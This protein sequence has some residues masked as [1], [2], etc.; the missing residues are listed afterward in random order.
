M[1]DD[2]LP[3]GALAAALAG[4]DVAA[5]ILAGGGSA[6][7]DE[8]R[9]IDARLVEARS[10]ET[11]LTEAQ[12]IEARLAALVALVRGFG[13]AAMVAGDP[14]LAERV[15]ADGVHAT[16]GAAPLRRR[17]DLALGVGAR[18]RDAAMEAGEV[19]A[20]YVFFGRL[21][22]D[23]HP[24]P[25]PGSLDLARWWANVATVPCIAPG[26]TDPASAVAVAETGADFVAL[27]SAIFEADNPGEMVGRVDA[28]LDAAVADG[29]APRFE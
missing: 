5:C 24:E 28:M 2:A 7:G 10:T 17:D 25:H 9:L 18:T 12:L 20:D 14:A 23:T 22:R 15:G 3:E 1:A 16:H 26:G 11:Q 27:R 19:G 13:V 4:G 29:R 6:G 21:L 8:A